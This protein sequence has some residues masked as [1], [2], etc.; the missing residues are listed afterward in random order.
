MEFEKYFSKERF[1]LRQVVGMLT[2]VIVGISVIAY[3]TVTIPY[4][5]TSGTTAK[6]SEV[7]ANFTALANAMPGIK[8]VYLADYSN[9]TSQ[10]PTGT[11]IYSIA[12]TPPSSYGA[13]E[14]SAQGTVCLYNHTQGPRQ[15]LILKISDSS[16]DVN[17]TLSADSGVLQL[18]D[19]SG[20]SPTYSGVWDREC[21]PFYI[22]KGVSV[23]S[24]NPMTLY[25]NAAVRS[26]NT[27]YPVGEIAA[28]YLKATYFPTVL[29]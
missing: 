15:G 19:V 8:D 20:A 2:M 12:V 17:E 23:T 28:L 3:A 4:T 29:Q 7:N 25:F 22:Q 16:G 9:I 18:F 6:S 14:I 5:F 13:I 26:T 24:T 11:Q 21:V 10:Y 1:S 27:T